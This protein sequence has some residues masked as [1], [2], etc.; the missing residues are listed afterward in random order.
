[1]LESSPVG[2]VSG[3]ATTNE[4]METNLGDLLAKAADAGKVAEKQPKMD[5]VE[6]MEALPPI[7][8]LL[9]DTVEQL[10]REKTGIFEENK[11]IEEEDTS[12]SV[13]A[14]SDEGSGS[15][16]LVDEEIDLI[17]KIVAEFNL[18]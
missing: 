9:G 12:P 8:T 16:S 4:D 1:M 15:S 7:E 18:N 11:E 3:L 17:D 14:S 10:K 5:F 2:K 13:P 6:S